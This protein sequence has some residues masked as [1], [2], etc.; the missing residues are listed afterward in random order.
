MPSGIRVRDLISLDTDRVVPVDDIPTVEDVMEA[1]VPTGFGDAKLKAA[2]SGSTRNFSDVNSLLNA[3]PDPGALVG[4]SVMGNPFRYVRGQYIPTGKINLAS[5]GAVMD[6][7]TSDHAAW[8]RAF[9]YAQRFA[10]YET[11]IQI[12][13]DSPTATSQTIK[14]P[15]NVSVEFVNDGLIRAVGSWTTPAKPVLQFGDANAN[16]EPDG[17]WRG[18]S[19]LIRVDC[20]NRANAIG[21]QFSRVW[22]GSNI[23]QVD[24]ANVRYKGVEVVSGYGLTIHKCDVRGV[25]VSTH[26]NH[27]AWNSCGL[28]VMTSDCQFITGDIE[29]LAYGVR[30]RSNNNYIGPM[31]P[32][33]IFE[34][35]ENYFDAVPMLVCFWN[36][37]QG[38]LFDGCIADSPCKRNY[39]AG[40]SLS[41]GGVG[42]L[43]EGDGYQ[44]R[45]I[46]CTVFIPDRT[47]QENIPEGMC[48][49][50]TSKEATFIG[51]EIDSQLPNIIAELDYFNGEAIDK[52]IIMGRQQVRFGRPWGQ[53]PARFGGAPSFPAGATINTQYLQEGMNSD[54][55]GD[56]YFLTEDQK[57]FQIQSN[58]GGQQSRIRIPREG[59]G[60]T[61]GRPTLNNQDGGYLYFNT[62]TGRFNF[63]TG[64]AWM[65]LTAS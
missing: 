6:G 43:N 15:Q 4:A 7:Q 29:F 57:W 54:G 42:F 3:T 41:N 24:V 14:F 10:T 31:H 55:W 20:N 56:A 46:G 30:T 36:Q 1:E 53:G 50:L 35:H 16:P 32:F 40:Y 49:F 65:T 48:G 19:Q 17:R 12:V 52:C 33:S 39:S 34:K 28:D 61:A 11:P 64:S 63:W 9:T 18:S 59:R 25:L 21:V 62:D 37:G 27:A 51:C 38:N 58:H 60:N 13:V 45:Y 23:N 22:A 44:T 8:A 47:V 2:I 5:F 26:G